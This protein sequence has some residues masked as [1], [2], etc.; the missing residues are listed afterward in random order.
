VTVPFF[1]GKLKHRG[2]VKCFIG[3]DAKKVLDTELLSR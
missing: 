1:E 2:Q 3:R